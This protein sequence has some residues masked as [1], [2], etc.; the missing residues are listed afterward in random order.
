MGTAV[1]SVS[2]DLFLKPDCAQVLG[3]VP[4]RSQVER[5]R[6]TELMPCLSSSHMPNPCTDVPMPLAHTAPVLDPETRRSA[7][8]RTV[9]QCIKGTARRQGTEGPF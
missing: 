5:L 1:T 8:T 7:T 2:P 6:D 4:G 9:V 3:R